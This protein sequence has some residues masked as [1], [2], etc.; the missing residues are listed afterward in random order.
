MENVLEK[1]GV[2]T[3]N[4]LLINTLVSL[5]TALM[6]NDLKKALINEQEISASLRESESRYR[7]LATNFPNGTL[8]L[9]DKDFRFLAADGQELKKHRLSSDELIGHTVDEVMPEIAHLFRSE[10]NQVFEG[11]TREFEFEY[12]PQ[13]FMN[14]ALPIAGCNGRI[15]Y[16][17]VITQDITERKKVEA[18]LRISERRFRALVENAPLGI[19][20]IDRK[21]AVLDVNS[22]FI[23]IIGAPSKQALFEIN[24]F[25]SPRIQ[26]TNYPSQLK[27]CMENGVSGAYESEYTSSWEKSV[28]L[29]YLLKPLADSNGNIYAALSIF[30]DITKERSQEEQLQRAQKMEALN[31]LAG[32]V[33]HDLNNVLSGIVSYP[34]LLLLD[35]PD[36]S[37]MRNQ[38]LTI[39][40]SGQRAAEIVQDLLT[41]ARRGVISVEVIN[42]NR[43]VSEYLDSPEFEKLVSHQATGSRQ[44]PG[45][46]RR[47]H[48]KQRDHPGRG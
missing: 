27:D 18:S 35:L 33:A 47:L 34:E 36:E 2:I 5:A 30:E 21:G 13:T 10:C 25:H 38:V 22:A 19:I 7:T 14:Q 9:I 4:F 1:W 20:T 6:L 11:K 43:I 26:L 24:V 12:G 16:G 42:L 45:A 3:V 41:L 31:L 8:C 48:G 23:E 39:Q 32:G 37:P 29:R 44:N 28:F 46:H 40:R 17:L 15:D